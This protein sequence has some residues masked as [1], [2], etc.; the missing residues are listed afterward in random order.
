MP[1]NLGEYSDITV[2]LGQDRKWLQEYMTHTVSKVERMVLHKVMND[3]PNISRDT[4][5]LIREM[6]LCAIDHDP[7][8]KTINQDYKYTRLNKQSKCEH[9]N[10]YPGYKIT[11]FR[12]TGW[13]GQY[14]PW[15][16]SKTM[17]EKDDKLLK[18][19]L[20]CYKGMLSEQ[21][22]KEII[23]TQL[24]WPRNKINML[25]DL[26]QSHRLINGENH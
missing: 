1:Q 19:I 21:E 2:L 17:I 3:T 22:E 15:R 8:M 20:F 12:Y 24:E 14:V 4:T 18:V 11:T 7:V 25:C 16:I 13:L 5:V 10:Q 23:E 26:A 6:G 9:M